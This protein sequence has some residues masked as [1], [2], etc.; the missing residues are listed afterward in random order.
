MLP[1]Q[2]VIGI[3]DPKVLFAANYQGFSWG[4]GGSNQPGR[5]HHQA[6]EGTV[7]RLQLDP[8]TNRLHHV[9]S[10]QPLNFPAQ[11]LV[12]PGPESQGW[13]CPRNLR[14]TSSS[15]LGLTYTRFG[16]LSLPLSDLSPTHPL[17]S[18][19]PDTA[20]VQRLICPQGPLYLP[21]ASVIL[22]LKQNHATFLLTLF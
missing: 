17:L 20:L 11:L 18:T 9:V 13:A 8:Q 5:G 6:E 10:R 15:S 21:A 2:G 1:R 19:A 16:V 14:A 22:F 7:A 12:L 3:L 4:F